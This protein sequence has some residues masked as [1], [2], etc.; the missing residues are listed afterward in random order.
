MAPWPYFGGKSAVASRVWAA[1]G[2]PAH[3]IEPFCGSCAVLLLRPNWKPEFT[4]TVN[5]ADGHIAN[6]WRSLQFAPDE[7]AKWCDWPVNHADLIARKR[8]LNLARE[9][10]VENLSTDDLWYDAK[11]AGYYIWAASC[12]IGSALQLSKSIPHLGDAGTGLHKKSLANGAIYDD[13][14][15]IHAKNIKIYDWLRRLSA[16][17]R[18]VR[19]VCGDWSRVC[20]GNWQDNLGVCGIFFDP[21]YGEKAERTNGC[22]AIDSLTVASDVQRWCLERGNSPNYRIV[23]AGY[24]EEHD[25]LL[26]HG[27]KVYRWS[28]SGGYASLGDNRGKKNRHR[29]ALFF[30]PHCLGGATL[31]DNDCHVDD[32]P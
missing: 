1:L 12:S 8:A 4:E 28:A 5:D 15:R 7:V 31:F 6:V 20:G 3:Y 30:S 18:R 26:A 13:A 16:R 32:T 27:W 14:S 11:L 2:Q 9:R 21:P 19:V 25:N 17:L 24:Y 22:Y 29:E 23:L 10:L